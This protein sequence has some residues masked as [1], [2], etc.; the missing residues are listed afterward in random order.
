MR[1]EHQ[2]ID[3]FLAALAA[4]TPTP[5]GGAVAPIIG[6]HGAA[7]ASMVVAYSL[8]RKNLAAHQP[9]LEAASAQL[10]RLRARFLDLAE[11]DAAAY[12]RLNEAMRTPADN[13]ARSAIVGP[14]ALDAIAPPEQAI[15]AG[16]E[17]LRLCVA[18]API[19]NRYLHSDLAMAGV[20]AEAAARAS[21]WNILVNVPLIR[22]SGV[23]A[24]DPLSRADG[25]LE[26]AG[27]LLTQLD[28]ACRP[29]S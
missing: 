7:L 29:S 13:P 23:E 6:A 16:L 3:A 20:F 5:G 14:A 17:L 25:L 9:A 4:K 26:Q 24:G 12:A 1:A 28:Q 15:V 10:E 22:D 18:L 21:R 2:T 19:T 27:A 8:G 11:A